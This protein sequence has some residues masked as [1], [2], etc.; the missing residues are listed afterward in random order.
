LLPATPP[1]FCGMLLPKFKQ[2]RSPKIT[3]FQK[4]KNV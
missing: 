4:A 2:S 3:A 1:K